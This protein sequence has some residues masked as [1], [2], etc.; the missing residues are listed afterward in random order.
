MSVRIRASALALT[1]ALPFS[2]APLHAEDALLEETV[3]VR[4]ERHQVRVEV[5]DTGIG[6]PPADRPR[7]FE[8]FYRVD[9]A[10]S[11]DLGGTG[12]GLAIVKHLVQAMGG[13]VYVDSE[14]GKGST[15]TFLL[16]R[17]SEGRGAAAGGAPAGGETGA[18]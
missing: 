1:L 10:R 3:R 7:I 16:P 12:L 9:K 18:G 14:P 2:A 11:R 6:I 15:F 5:A 17:V 4:E 8:R 13:E